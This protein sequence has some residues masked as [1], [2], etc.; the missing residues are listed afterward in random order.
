M[1][2]RGWYVGGEHTVH[3][4]VSDNERIELTHVL[5]IG[6]YLLME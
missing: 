3:V 1:L 6:P 2:L 4:L 5:A